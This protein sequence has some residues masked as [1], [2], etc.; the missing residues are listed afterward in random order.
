MEGIPTPS[1]T[2]LEFFFFFFFGSSTR[3]SGEGL[4]KYFEGSIFLDLVSR[5][6]F[7]GFDFEP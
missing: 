7:E 2:E 1:K 5:P 3:T 4:A 6:S